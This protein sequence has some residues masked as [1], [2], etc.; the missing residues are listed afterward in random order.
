MPLKVIPTKEVIWRWILCKLGLRRNTHR[1]TLS[2]DRRRTTGTTRWRLC[3]WLFSLVWFVLAKKR[4]LSKVSQRYQGW[5]D[6]GGGLG[7]VCVFSLGLLW[8]SI[9]KFCPSSA[10]LVRLLGLY[11]F[12]WGYHIY[13]V[14]I[15][16]CIFPALVTEKED[17]PNSWWIWVLAFDSR[18]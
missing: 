11:L 18:T 14:L 5:S 15:D 6:L 2:L 1:D 12:C 7:C 8:W 13:C 4:K 9:S 16:S 10:A 17:Q 3:S